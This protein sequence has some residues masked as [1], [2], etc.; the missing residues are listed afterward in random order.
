M[1]TVTAFGE[2]EL[3]ALPIAGVLA[4]MTNHRAARGEQRKKNAAAA[5]GT[6]WTDFA[7]SM[8]GGGGR[9]LVLGR[10]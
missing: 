4:V 3:L 7:Q 2:T 10:C 1:V 9:G 8:R 5:I 6:V